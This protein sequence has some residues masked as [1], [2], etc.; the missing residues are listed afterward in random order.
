MLVHVDERALN[1]IKKAWMCP[2]GRGIVHP[3]FNKPGRAALH[4]RLSSSSHWRQQIEC[5]S[6]QQL[7]VLY[8]VYPTNKRWKRFSCLNV[9][10]GVRVLPF[11]H[12]CWRFQCS[13]HKIDGKA[14]FALFCLRLHSCS[15][16][17]YRRIAVI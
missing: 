14:L 3:D 2:G 6:I 16:T 10:S 13:G 9:V 17:R 5:S 7:V 1:M 8:H 12:V 4:I 11:V 15:Y